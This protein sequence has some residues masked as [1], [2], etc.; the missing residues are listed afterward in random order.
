MSLDIR[1]K[2][3]VCPLC[4]KG[5]YVYSCN[6][7]HNLGPMAKEAGMYYCLWRPDEINVKCAKEIVKTLEFGLRMMLQNPDV[8]RKLD[9][10][11]GWGTY[12]DFIPWLQEYIEA[13]RNYPDA[14]IEVSR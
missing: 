6:I 1:L 2:D 7:T 11:N 4:G 13:C 10:P 5:E 12:N 14:T 3:N 8:Y 9:A